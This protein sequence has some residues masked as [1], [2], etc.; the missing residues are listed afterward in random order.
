MTAGTESLGGNH[1]EVSPARGSDE[2]SDDDDKNR[3]R[4]KRKKRK[5]RRRDEKDKHD[6]HDKVLYEKLNSRNS[7]SCETIKTQNFF[8]IRFNKYIYQI[9]WIFVSEEEKETQIS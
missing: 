3:R 6:K 1:G 9:T 5:K 4:D 2:E 7:D 8:I